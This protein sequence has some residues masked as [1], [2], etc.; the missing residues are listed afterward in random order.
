M[1]INSYIKCLR[2]FRKYEILQI[3]NKITLFPAS[4]DL[5]LQTLASGID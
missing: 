5:L 1:I 3:K 2:E 4:L